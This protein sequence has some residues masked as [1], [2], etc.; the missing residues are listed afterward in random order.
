LVVSSGEIYACALE[1]HRATTNLVV[2]KSTHPNHCAIEVK[3]MANAIT[4]SFDGV[5]VWTGKVAEGS[6]A[7]LV[8]Y[9]GTA[10]FQNVR[11]DRDVK[12]RK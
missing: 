4:V 5:T 8:V 7:G 2:G 11:V 9:R 12:A 6:R 10:Q 1:S 3:Q